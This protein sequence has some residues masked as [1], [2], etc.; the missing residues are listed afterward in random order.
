MEYDAFKVADD[1]VVAFALELIG[2]KYVVGRNGTYLQPIVSLFFHARQ[3]FLQVL[4]LVP[5]RLAHPLT[6]D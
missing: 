4:I 5:C 1:V 6:A 3:S 2:Q